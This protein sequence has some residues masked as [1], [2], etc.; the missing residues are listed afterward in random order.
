MTG[1]L[2][3]LNPLAALIAVIIF[4]MMLALTKYDS[5]SS[6]TTALTL[7]VIFGAWLQGGFA[8]SMFS[9]AAALIILITHRQ[10]IK[11]LMKGQ[12]SKTDLFGK[13]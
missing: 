8:L 4:L 3:A 6:I 5:L 1:T 9:F 11:R 2:L 7:P 10:N 13:K 12:E